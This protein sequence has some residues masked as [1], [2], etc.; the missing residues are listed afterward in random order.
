MI[1]QEALLRFENS[2]MYFLK[3]LS[4]LMVNKKSNHKKISYNIQQGSTNLNLNLLISIWGFFVSLYSNLW[5]YSKLAQTNNLPFITL[6]KNVS[7]ISTTSYHSKKSSNL[8][9]LLRWK[10]FFFLFLSFWQLKCENFSKISRKCNLHMERIDMNRI[11]DEKIII[12]N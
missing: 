9:I 11:Y 8:L 1:A 12:S 3:K 4:F 6:T 2:S 7:L 5:F 10:N